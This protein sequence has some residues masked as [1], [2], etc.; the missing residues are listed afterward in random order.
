MKTG[1]KIIATLALVCRVLLLGRNTY[2]KYYYQ[3]A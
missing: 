2:V 3:N 1:L